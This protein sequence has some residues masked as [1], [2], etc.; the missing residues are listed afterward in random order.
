[1]PL[2][3][4]KK[5]KEELQALQH[6][7]DSYKIGELIDVTTG[8]PLD[9]I[10]RVVPPTAAKRLGQRKEA[11]GDYTPLITPDWQK[12]AVKKNTQE[13]CMKRVGEFLLEVVK[14]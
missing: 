2:P 14:E 8:Q 12:L 9:R 4:A 3:N 10:K 13:S 11:N 5:D 6:W 7:L 1:M